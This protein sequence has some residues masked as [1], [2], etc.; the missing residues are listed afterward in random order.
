[1]RNRLLTAFTR[2][3]G[4][5]YLH[6]VLNPLLEIMLTKPS[7]YSYEIERSLCKDDEEHVQ[8]M[9][10]VRVITEAFLNVV[11]ESMNIIPPYVSFISLW[12]AI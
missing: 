6:K 7:G 4:Y 1:M 9:E 12:R 10:H 5:Q 2:K 3:H 11:V 8:N